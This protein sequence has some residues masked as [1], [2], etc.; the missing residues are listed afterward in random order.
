MMAYVIS[1]RPRHIIG[2]LSD[3]N[4]GAIHGVTYDKWE[5]VVGSATLYCK[6]FNELNEHAVKNK[7][8][9]FK[10]WQIVV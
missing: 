7:F 8:V 10:L 2:A 5:G 3:G 1:N 9:A 6:R 4:G